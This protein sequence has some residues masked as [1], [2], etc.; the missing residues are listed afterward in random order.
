LLFRVSS[1]EI[2]VTRKL[3]FLSV[4]FVAL[5]ACLA[6]AIALRVRSYQANEAFARVHS[7]ETAAPNDPASDPLRMQ[8]GGAGVVVTNDGVIVPIANVGETTQTIA[9]PERVARAAKARE[10]RYNELLRQGAPPAA[11]AAQ[12]RAESVIGDNG[13]TENLPS[14]GSSG[15]SPGHRA[16]TP[17]G[18]NR[19]TPQP[20]TNRPVQQQPNPQQPQ[21]KPEKPEKPPE[22]TEPPDPNSDL[23]PPQLLALE[24]SPNQ[25][26]DNETT[27]LIAQVVDDLSGVATVSGVISSPTGA[28]QGF[29]CQREAETS[30]YVAQVKVPQDAAEGVWRVNYL[31]LADNARNSVNLSAAQGMLPPTA[32]F[33][34]TSSNSDSTG[35]GLKAVWIDRQAMK[36]G[37]RNLIYVQAEDEKSGVQVVSGVLLSPSRNARIGFGCQLNGQG[38]WECP[39]TPPTCL[40]C[41]LWT[42]EQIQVQDKASNMTNFRADNPLVKN[43]HV[44]IS[45]DQ[46]DSQPP[47]LT[48]LALDPIVVANTEA[49][50][51]LARV[52]VTD[53]VCGVA[54]V[55]GQAAGP[56]AG[57]SAPRLY[58][59]FEKQGEQWVARI[60]VP[61]HAARGVW[62]IVWIQALDTGHNLKAYSERDPA[63]QG[64]TFRVN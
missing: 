59:S 36:A 6:G 35:P 44:D 15:R 22:N 58:F 48:S 57:P 1:T 61:K 49:N 32:A 46:C 12:V 7:P 2:P 27:T 55:S 9:S 21:P 18:I 31:T 10:E 11:A 28:L 54:N 5:G 34:V 63:L 29:A 26:K 64:I 30:R 17:L 8:R 62:K 25:V 20:A 53:D 4:F 16:S 51:I 39:V 43:L 14:S 41:G 47:Q 52:N 42:L 45:A 56:G 50:T 3:S 13:E 24:F 60:S 37:E 40:D 38:V 23:T 19:S 33:R